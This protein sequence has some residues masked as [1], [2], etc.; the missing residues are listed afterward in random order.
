MLFIT[1]ENTNANG[2]MKAIQ[3][4]ALVLGGV[5]GIKVV[6]VYVLKTG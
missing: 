3:H 4:S 1:I 5:V 6:H 2:K